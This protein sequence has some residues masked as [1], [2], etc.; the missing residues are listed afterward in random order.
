MIS[1][2]SPHNNIQRDLLAEL[3][4]IISAHDMH[5]RMVRNNMDDDD[6][7]VTSS[8]TLKLKVTKKEREYQRS[9]L[10]MPSGDKKLID[11]FSCSDYSSDPIDNYE[12]ESSIRY[13]NYK[14]NNDV[15]HHCQKL[16]KITA[17]PT[18]AQ[19]TILV[20]EIRRSDSTNS[21][22]LD[23][24]KRKSLQWFRKRREYLALKVYNVCDEL[25][26]SVWDAVVARSEVEN[27]SNKLTYD[28]TVDEIVSDDLLMMTIF[29]AAKLPVKDK[30]NGVSFVRRK[31]KDYF[32]KLCIRTTNN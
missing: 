6:L 22:E 4:Q 27:D 20:H 5:M 14:Y 24:I 30:T 11:D 3:S 9:P 29:E 13:R 32:N 10:G 7:F 17:Y 1:S 23:V 28:A 2:S 26:E 21:Q 25:M 8:D 15:A 31:V 12:I 18:V 16:L 19:I